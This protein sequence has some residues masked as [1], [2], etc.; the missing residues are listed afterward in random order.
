VKKI[1]KIIIKKAGVF[2][3]VLFAIAIL[4]EF[5]CLLLSLFR[6][7]EGYRSLVRAKEQHLLKV[8]ELKAPS[9]FELQDLSFG[10]FKF[11]LHPYWGFIREPSSMSNNMGFLFTDGDYPYAAASKEFVIG[12]FGGSIAQHFC[13]YGADLLSSGM[14]KLLESKGYDRITVLCFAELA[15]R[16]PQSLYAFIYFLDT[17]DMAI[18]LEGFNE[19]VFWLEKGYPPDFPHI[20]FW[21]PLASIKFSPYEASLLGRIQTSTES[22]KKITKTFLKTPLKHSM[23]AHVIWRI[24]TNDKIRK[25]NSLTREL[26]KEQSREYFYRLPEGIS[27]KQLRERY[28]RQYEDIIRI[29]SAIGK[30]FQKPVFHIL[31]PNQYLDGSKKFSEV[32]TQK[33]RVNESLHNFV[34]AGYP[35]MQSLYKNFKRAG[36][37]TLDFSMLFREITETIYKDD[38]CHLNQLGNELIAEAFLRELGNRPELLETIPRAG[39]RNNRF[40][41][42]PNA[43]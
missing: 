26:E 12:I 9:Q 8:G 33:F 43:E 1:G 10:K 36:I 38:C 42:T 39:S 30:V 34:S 29:T 20:W 11:W 22:R 35:V 23:F 24:L 21:K 2:F 32:E 37:N 27:Q 18:F 16:Q 17:I 19:A 31:Q 13:Q 25:E 41:C 14:E 4:L 6:F 40:L 5:S 28:F 3:L 7:S 15:H